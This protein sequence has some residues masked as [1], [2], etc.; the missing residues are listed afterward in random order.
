MKRIIA[1]VAGLVF[2][3]AAVAAA[4]PPDQMIRAT[5]DQLRTLIDKNHDSYAKNNTQFYKV[6]DDLLVP[7]FDTK[8]IAQIILARN[9]R[10]ATDD[11]R[12]RFQNAFKNMLIDNYAD[13]LLENYNSVDVDYKPARIDPDG[14]DSTV[15]CQ[16]VR[17][18]G[19][20]PI[21]ISFKLRL[22]GDQWEIF[23]VIVENISLV[24]NF[25]TQVASEI[26]RTSLDDVISRMEK[27]EL[28]KPVIDNKAA[29]P[30]AGGAAG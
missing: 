19:K 27:G 26:K 15:D 9:W 18:D 22:D 25:R 3:V 28:L 21:N 2:A 20:P 17:K 1:L 29:Q 10:T 24:L 12:T 13:E 23:D 6:V 16:I 4:T 14:T 7:H 8:Y 30:A 11:Q 5:T